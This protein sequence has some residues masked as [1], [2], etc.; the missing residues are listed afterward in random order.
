VS[1]SFDLTVPEIF[2]QPLDRIATLTEDQFRSLVALLHEQQLLTES[3]EQVADRIEGKTSTEINSGAALSIL[4]FAIQ[5]RALVPRIGVPAGRI[6]QAVATAYEGEPSSGEI[7]TRVHQ[8]IDSPFIALRNKVH[9]LSGRPEPK[10][11]GVRILTDMRPIFPVDERPT[12]VIGFILI[13]TIEFEIEKDQQEET[14]TMVADKPRLMALRD[15]LDRALEKH[16]T[17]E[18]TLSAGGLTDLTV[19]DDDESW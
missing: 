7:E 19:E 12:E 5:T 8:L 10:L 2:R 9:D 14:L 11:T 6:A 17:L 4:A 18:G 13:D 1:A 3:L 15:A 16:L